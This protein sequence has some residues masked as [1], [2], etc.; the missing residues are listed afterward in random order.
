MSKSNMQ[1][2]KLLLKRKDTADVKKFVRIK[3]KI[4][5]NTRDPDGMSTKKR[6]YKN[7]EGRK[8]RSQG[9]RKHVENLDV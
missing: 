7:I 5:R 2:K 6:P 9:S 3:M 4:P 8:S 1:M